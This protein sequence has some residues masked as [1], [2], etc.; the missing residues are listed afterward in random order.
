MSRISW[1]DFRK[2]RVKRIYQAVRDFGR[3]RYIAH[4]ALAFFSLEGYVA[5]IRYAPDADIG[6]HMT[7]GMGYVALILIAL[8]LLIGPF[9]LLYKRANPVNVNLRRDVGIWA[10]LTGLLHVFFGLQLHNRGN[11]LTY[12]FRFHEDGSMTLLLNNFGISND[13]GLIATLILIALLV[14]SNNLSLR[15]LKGRRWKTLQRFNYG[16]FVLVAAHTFLYQQVSRR[17]QLF[18]TA[19]ILLTVV[20]VAGQFAGLLI[21]K[22][23]QKRRMHRH[24]PARI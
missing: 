1:T 19:S 14:T 2:R 21:F 8:S 16:L 9:R 10:G 6:Y 3:D 5:A 23:R 18:V 20:V 22:A 17:E 13:V 12:F 7:L 24:I 11:L 4:A 15:K